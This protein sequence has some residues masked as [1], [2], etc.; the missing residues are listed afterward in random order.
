MAL[1]PQLYGN[2]TPVPFVDEMFVLR[3]DAVDFEVDKVAEY[4]PKLISH[5]L[6]VPQRSA[7]F[8]NVNSN[9]DFA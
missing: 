3:R 8:C 7:Q 1:N 6:S 9:V 5:S 4:A 2:S